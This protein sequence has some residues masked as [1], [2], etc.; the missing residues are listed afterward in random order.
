MR[1]IPG[2]NSFYSAPG[3]TEWNIIFSFAGH[4]AGLTSN[5][6]VKID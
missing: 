6:S 1:I 5:T 3:S 2:Q 4:L